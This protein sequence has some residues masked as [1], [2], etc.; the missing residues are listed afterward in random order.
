MISDIVPKTGEMM[1]TINV[2]MLKPLLQ[3]AVAI[4]GLER[5]APA[6]WL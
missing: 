4:A 6:T 2:A 5:V 3:Y 1:A